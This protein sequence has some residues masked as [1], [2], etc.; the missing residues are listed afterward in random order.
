ML[1]KGLFITFEGGEGAG[2]SSLIAAIAKLFES[3][4]ITV[5]CTREPGGTPLGESIRRLLLESKENV[6]IDS[7]AELFLF[8]ASRSQHL[9]EVIL[10]SIENGW[11]VLC[12]RFND[13]TIAYQGSA[14][15]LG[16]EYVQKLCQLACHG[17][18]PDMTLLLDVPVEVGLKRTRAAH[19][20]NAAEGMVDRI[21]SEAM[22]FHQK[23]RD[24]LL[25][26][27]KQDPQRCVIID[28]SQSQEAVL[29]SAISS[30]SDRYNV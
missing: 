27:A 8:L 11:V 24:A 17:R 6:L 3:K 25:M 10:P 7:T 9:E 14:R 1:K 19:K 29:K 16:V 2:K 12:D 23:V 30:L 20:E 21:E 18:E 4:G 5:R 28:A 22:T 26:R 15:G 13:S